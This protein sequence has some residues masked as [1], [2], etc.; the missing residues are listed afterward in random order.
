MKRNWAWDTHRSHRNVSNGCNDL[1]DPS[2]LQIGCT[3]HRQ[4][5]CNDLDASSLFLT[6][7]Q[8][9]HRHIRDL[10]FF[11]RRQ[12]EARSARAPK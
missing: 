1:D 6:R 12:E 10:G 7:S 2:T 4:E 8:R 3:E 9:W 11:V 5:R